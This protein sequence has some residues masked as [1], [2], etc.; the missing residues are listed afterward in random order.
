VG[1]DSVFGMTVELRE[2]TPDDFALRAVLLEHT[3]PPDQQDFAATAVESLPLGDRDPDRLSVGIVADG[4]P[5]GMF[6]L[7]RGGYFREFD[8][9]PGVVLLRAFYIAPEHQGSGYAKEAVSATRA[10]VQQRLPDVKRLVLTV[11]HRNPAAIATYLK[12]GFGQTGQ[13]Y[14]GGPFGP[15]HVMVLEI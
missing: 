13:D 6:A 4:V 8:D 12:G 2:I 15:Q 11:N 3:L 9:D 10:F 5:V 14:L 7:D 1:A